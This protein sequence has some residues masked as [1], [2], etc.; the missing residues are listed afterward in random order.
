[1]TVTTKFTYKD[2]PMTGLTGIGGDGGGSGWELDNRLDLLIEAV[3]TSAPHESL[4]LNV[5]LAD[6]NIVKG[7]NDTF[8]VTHNAI[9]N[10]VLT[11]QKVERLVCADKAKAFDV[12]GE[13]GEVYAL[14]SAGLGQS[15]VTQELLGVGLWLK[16]QGKTDTELAQILL[17]SALY[18]QDALGTSNETFVK[19]VYKNVIGE[20]ISLADLALFT[21]WLDNKSMTQAELLDTA[22]NLELFRDADHIN[23]VGLASTGIT[24]E[25]FGV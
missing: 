15:D 2:L 13:A 19:H 17:D 18:K 25:V 14:L 4:E 11:L 10:T 8:V 5:N 24:Y 1:M 7:R 12:N 21:S 23:L 20:T 16:D 9:N 6:L 22:S 3:G